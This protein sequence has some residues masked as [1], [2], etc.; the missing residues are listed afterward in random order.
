MTA[1]GLLRLLDSPARALVVLRIACLV[2]DARDRQHLCRQRHPITSL[3]VRRGPM[4]VRRGCLHCLPLLG[5][6]NTAPRGDQQTSTSASALAA[7]KPLPGQE[8]CQR[9]AHLCQHPAGLQLPVPGSEEE[10]DKRFQ[11]RLCGDDG[12]SSAAHCLRNQSSMRWTRSGGGSTRLQTW[13]RC[14]RDGNQAVIIFL[15]FQTTRHTQHVLNRLSWTQ[16]S[17]SAA[18]R[19]G[20]RAT[21]ARNV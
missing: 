11:A 14:D 7:A 21:N 17:D 2:S 5:S 1:I 19:A 13:L 8:H 20:S 4:G 18:G 6:E 10:N 12:S 9:L 16:S 15:S 3:S